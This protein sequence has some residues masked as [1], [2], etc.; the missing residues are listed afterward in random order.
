MLP[1]TATKYRRRASD[2]LIAVR[3]NTW[4]AQQL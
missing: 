3:P 2:D 4:A 1:A